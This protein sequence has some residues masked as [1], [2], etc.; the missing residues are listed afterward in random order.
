M[1]KKDIKNFY[2]LVTNKQSM[3]EAGCVHCEIVRCNSTGI[4]TMFTFDNELAKYLTAFRT[5]RFNAPFEEGND[6]NQ[7]SLIQEFDE[8]FEKYKLGWKAV[9]E[10]DPVEIEGRKSS[11]LGLILVCKSNDLEAHRGS[12]EFANVILELLNVVQVRIDNFVN[13]E[14]KHFVGVRPEYKFWSCLDDGIF[15]YQKLFELLTKEGTNFHDLVKLMY[16]E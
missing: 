9:L 14:L 15:R 4:I 1:T 12:E 11:C 7:K 16:Q 8:V 3:L 2:K 5:L 10:T 13:T 6:F